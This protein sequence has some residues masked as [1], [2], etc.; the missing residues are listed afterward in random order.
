MKNSVPFQAFRAR[1]SVL[2]VPAAVLLLTCVVGAYFFSRGRNIMREELRGHLRS[3]AA[4]ASLS[5]DPSLV[6]VVRTEDDMS[7]PA[8]RAL[9]TQVQRIRQSD[10]RILY[11]YV[12]RR[13]ADPDVLSFVIDAD[14]ALSDADLDRDGDGTVGEDE[15]PAL[16]GESY[17]V[18]GDAFSVLRVDAFEGPAV[19]TQIVSDKWGA[20]ISGYAPVRDARGN[21][22]AVLGIDMD[23][24]AFLSLSQSIFSPIAL[25][26]LVIAGILLAAY[27]QYVAHRRA[28]QSVGQ[29]EAE[30]TALLDLA[31]HQLGMP[32]AT[33]K[34]W[35]E[36][37]RD[38][39]N[40]A[41][42]RENGICDEMQQGI[43][44]MDAI[45]RSLHDANHLEKGNLNYHPTS[46]VLADVIRASIASMKADLAKRGQELT[47]AQDGDVPPVSVD[48]KLI[49]GVISEL[50]ENAHM[51]SPEGARISIRLSKTR[52]AAVV[53]VTDTGYGIAQ[54]ELGGLFAKFKRGRDAMK[55]K[56]VGNGLGLFIAKGIIERAGGSISLK[57]TLGQGTSIRIL[58]PFAL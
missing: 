37:L 42:C 23:A 45:I 32:L 28:A 4:V 8:F 43:D 24:G 13:T 31:T 47:F 40:G 34:W 58:L 39:D 35:L 51:Y 26:L 46:T 5:V 27:I 25:L 11:A 57:S 12:M 15:A 54:D 10:D 16:P 9:L 56:P 36:I 49:G 20:S 44:R 55:R 19:D 2:V 52:T 29:V 3:T 50:I 21:V 48:P 18:S 17:D 41:F 6:A 14:S 30:R 33:F 53:E 1:L 22:I 38:K 7:K